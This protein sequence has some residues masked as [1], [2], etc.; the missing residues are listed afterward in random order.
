VGRNLVV[1][2]LE[3]AYRAAGEAFL[4]RRGVMSGIELSQRPP[5]QVVYPESDGQPMAETGIHVMVILNLI[6]ALRLYFRARDDVYITGDM[7]LYYEE[8]RPQSRK[9]PDVMVIQGVPST[10]E[11]RSFFVW[12]EQAVP[13]CIFEI[14]SKETAD[15]DRKGKR[16]L[17]RRIGVREY[18]LFDPLHE[19]L[20]QRLMGYRLNGEEYEPL[21]PGPDESLVSEELGLRLVPEEG[22]LALFMRSTGE[23]VPTPPEMVL[24]MEAAQ[25]RADQEQHRADQAERRTAELERELQRLRALLPPAPNGGAAGH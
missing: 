19:Y 21:T 13:C 14:T 22:N 9:A 5:A 4:F 1:E 24:L 2:N 8:G 20:D 23:R 15:E 7:F 17:Y 10:P 11:R 6:A 3:V 18:F 12:V 25:Q 16:D